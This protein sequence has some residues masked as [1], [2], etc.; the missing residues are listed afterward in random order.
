MIFSMSCFYTKHQLYARVDSIREEFAILNNIPVLDTKE[1]LTQV[2]NLQIA[3]VPFVTSALHGICSFGKSGESDVI[4]LNANRSLT[5][6]NFDGMHEFIHIHEHRGEPKDSF[7]C[8]DR[9]TDK[10][11]SFLEWQA[12]EGAAEMLVPYRDFIPRFYRHFCEMKQDPFDGVPIQAKLADFY[13][14]ST[15]VIEN[16]IQS[17]SY[18]IH[19]YSQGVPIC[20]IVL[21]SHAQQKRQGIQPPDYNDIYNSA[22]IQDIFER[23]INEPDYYCS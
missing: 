18:E 3:S 4:L 13:S 17:L 15:Q 7:R 5:E 22:F 12:N 21:M 9:V 14:V 19:Q 1:F 6:R 23:S 10:Q 20:E 11:N 8:Y 16:R 2:P